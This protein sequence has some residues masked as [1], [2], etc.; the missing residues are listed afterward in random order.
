MGKSMIKSLHHWLNSLQNYADFKLDIET[1]TADL[2]IALY[3]EIYQ[4]LSRGRAKKILKHIY[5]KKL[6]HRCLLILCLLNIV[7]SLK[8]RFLCYQSS[9]ADNNANLF[10]NLTLATF[11]NILYRSLPGFLRH[12]CFIR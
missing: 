1:F 3:Y 4:V 12:C 9:P 7:N 11:Q 5:T 8:M 10:Q 2:T 6:Q